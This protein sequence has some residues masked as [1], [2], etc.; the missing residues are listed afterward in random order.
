ML[1]PNSSNLKTQH[2][3]SYR[4]THHEHALHVPGYRILAF[5]WGNPDLHEKIPRYPCRTIGWS[6][7]FH[8]GLRLL[9]PVLGYKKRRGSQPVLVPPVA[10]Y[11]LRFY[12]LRVD[13]ALA[14]SRQAST[15]VVHTHHR[16]LVHDL[17]AQS[18]FRNRI[19]HDIHFKRNGSLSRDHGP[20]LFVGYAILC[21]HN[22]RTTDPAKKINIPWILAIGILVQFAWE[23]VLLITGIRNPS[24]MTIVVNSLLETNLGLPYMYFIHRAVNKRYSEDLSR[25][26]IQIKA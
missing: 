26:E 18:N 21:I 9:L 25:H 20:H 6:T 22:I 7:V 2:Y 23:F 17:V 1:Q 24:F 3:G 16:L 11:E 4:S 12:Q 15:G 19:R 14:R 5:P 13:M 10:E 8:R